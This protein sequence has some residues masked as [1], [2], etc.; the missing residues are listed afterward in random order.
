MVD[1]EDLVTTYKPHAFF[2]RWLCSSYR[3]WEQTL[4]EC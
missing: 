4:K 2:R 3:N 1:L